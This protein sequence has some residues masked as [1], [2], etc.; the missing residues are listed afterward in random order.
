MYELRTEGDAIDDNGTPEE[1]TRYIYSNHLQSSSLEL[2]EIGDIIS[3]EEYHP[4]GTT[5][6]QALDATIKA[7]YKRYRYTGKE[8]DDESGLYYH[9]ARYYIP[10]LCRWS[11]ADPME[12]KYAGWSGYQY[13]TCNP[14]MNTDSTGMGN[15]DEKQKFKTI[16]I[17]NKSGRT[18]GEISNFIDPESAGNITLPVLSINLRAISED[19]FNG[20]VNYNET[21]DYGAQYSPLGDEIPTG[22]KISNSIK[23]DFQRIKEDFSDAV[24]KNTKEDGATKEQLVAIY[25][26]SKLNMISSFLMPDSNN[27]TNSAALTDVSTTYGKNPGFSITLLTP[28]EYMQGGLNAKREKNTYE[29]GIYENL[30]KHSGLVLIAF[31]H[32]HPSKEM[33]L[34]LDRADP[35]KNVTN[36]SYKIDIITHSDEDYRISQRTGLPDFIINTFKG[37]NPDNISVEL[38]KFGAKNKEDMEKMENFSK[39]VANP[40]LIIYNI[41]QNYKRF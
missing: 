32:T 2:D 23:A 39:F 21:F 41:I 5:S 14:I 4:F 38:M 13:T 29:F 11:A 25:Y 35:N 19:D 18:L 7:S 26:N 10:W 8:R 1:L 34:K 20:I 17:D 24:S 30:E 28:L 22:K 16:F 37:S 9:G 31:G 36:F 15:D 27:T 12:G 3:Y 40:S 6:Y 33:D